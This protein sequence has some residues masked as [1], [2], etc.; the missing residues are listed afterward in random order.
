MSMSKEVRKMDSRET[1]PALK[2]MYWQKFCWDTK[3]LPVGLLNSSM[4]ENK[5]AMKLEITIFSIV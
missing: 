2:F 3:N 1:H 5:P 4:M